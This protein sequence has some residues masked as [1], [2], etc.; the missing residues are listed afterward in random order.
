[1]DVT[2]SLYYLM[3][4][5]DVILHVPGV[6]GVERQEE[7][8][9]LEEEAARMERKKDLGE[10]EMVFYV[11]IAWLWLTN[12][13][14]LQRLY[15]YLLLTRRPAGAVVTELSGKH[16]KLEE[17]VQALRAAYQELEERI[18]EKDRELE[19]AETRKMRALAHQSLNNEE[20][21]KKRELRLLELELQMERI[22][23]QKMVESGELWRLLES[24]E[25]KLKLQRMQ[26]RTMLSN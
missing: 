25:P 5:A 13:L 22:Q 8:L 11:Y 17:E 14:Y 2:L 9:R 12:L 16:A 23:I 20:A 4:N 21:T 26:A 3:I 10:C 1:M 6:A 15:L 7:R 18:A 24:L 19:G